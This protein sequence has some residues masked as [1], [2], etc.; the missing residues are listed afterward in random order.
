MSTLRYDM[1]T[2]FVGAKFLSCA[3]SFFIETCP[4]VGTK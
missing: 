2:R 3:K 4:E 1:T